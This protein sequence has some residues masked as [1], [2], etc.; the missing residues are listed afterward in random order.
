MAKEQEDGETIRY[1]IRKLVIN[2]SDDQ[3]HNYGLRYVEA[4][5]DGNLL[6][7]LAITKFERERAGF[8]FIDSIILREESEGIFSIH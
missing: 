7:N 1:L 5:K 8:T 3:F 4:K 6:T 2:S